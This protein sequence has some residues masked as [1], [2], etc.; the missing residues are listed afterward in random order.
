MEAGAEQRN[1]EHGTGRQPVPIRAT[2]AP[3]LVKAA[4]EQ[5]RTV[6]RAARLP[7]DLWNGSDPMRLLENLAQR[8]GVVQRKCQVQRVQ[9]R[10]LNRRVLELT[11]LLANSRQKVS[12]LDRENAKLR[13]LLSDQAVAGEAR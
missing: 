12:Q 5:A 10:A 1:R 4:A 2:V 6:L 3:E 7:S 8:F 11:G 9:L 13:T